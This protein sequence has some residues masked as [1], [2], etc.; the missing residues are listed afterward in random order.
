MFQWTRRF[1]WTL[2]MIAQAALMS[3]AVAQTDEALA[4]GDDEVVVIANVDG[5]VLD[6]APEK[7]EP[8][9]QENEGPKE[10]K[11]LKLRVVKPDGAPTEKGERI[12]K[13]VLRLKEGPHPAARGQVKV[14]SPD[15]KSFELITVDGGLMTLRQGVRPQGAF[16][17]SGDVQSGDA[18][19]LQTLIGKLTERIND[20]AGTEPP[21]FVI[22]VQV[23]EAPEVVL[24][25]IGKPESKA[26]VVQSVVEQSPAAKAGV[27][28]FD[29][30]LKAAGE[31]V[32]SPGELTKVVKDADGQEIDLELVRS[33]KALMVRV[34]PKSNEQADARRHATDATI[35]FGPAMMER[36]H[37]FANEP[38]AQGGAVL[39]EIK[40]LRKDVEELKK[41][42]EE[43]KATK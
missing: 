1:A 10:G 22:G 6:G 18:E 11:S 3:P 37:F 28:K 34:V 9:K 16:T 17:F 15:G 33:G 35:Y 2:P 7:A 27:Q 25:Q 12:V 40:G 30:I 14:V 23:V 19:E 8:P 43:L 36:R 32:G 31:P 20:K 4:E 38:G 24:S 39:E 13:D 26:V 5:E 41:L 21:K 29:L 42:V